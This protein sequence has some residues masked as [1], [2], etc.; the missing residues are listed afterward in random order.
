MAAPDPV[1]VLDQATI[2]EMTQAAANGNHG[3]IEEI[4]AQAQNPR[5]AVNEVNNYGRTAIQVMNTMCESTART[6]INH[7]AN[8]NIPDPDV[9]RTIL[10]DVAEKGS[11][12]VLDLLLQNGADV[13]ARDNWGNTPAHLAASEGRDIKVLE[14]LSQFCT[15]REVNTE[16]NTPLDLAREKGHQQVVEWIQNHHTRVYSLQFLVRR[17][18]RIR[19]RVIG[20]SVGNF[21]RPLMDYLHGR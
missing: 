10:H 2:N 8:V 9:R 18:I 4:L 13:I 16:G 6:L 21:P 15:L 5:D 14:R 3:R 12:E 1:D 19:V 11:I 7:G 20:N 17:L